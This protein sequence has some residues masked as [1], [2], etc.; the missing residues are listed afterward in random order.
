[1]NRII[2]LRVKEINN[3]VRV[4]KKDKESFRC[5]IIVLSSL[6]KPSKVM[7]LLEKTYKGKR[8]RIN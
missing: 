3:L 7:K 6:F 8:R 1:M 5:L 2:Q 4:I